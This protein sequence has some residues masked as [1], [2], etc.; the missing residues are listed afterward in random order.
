[1]QTVKVD[2]DEADA[3]EANDV[4][5]QSAGSGSSV[6]AIASSEANSRIRIA[7]RADP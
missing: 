2:P 5:E 6:S 4:P 1:M 7:A 3:A